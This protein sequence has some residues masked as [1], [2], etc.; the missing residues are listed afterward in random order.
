MAY[1][2]SQIAKRRTEAS[3]PSQTASST[4]KLGSMSSL[5]G[6][7]VTAQDTSNTATQTSALQRQPAALGKLHE[8]DLGAEARALNEERTRRRI[9]GERSLEEE[10]AEALAAK[11]P[12][13]VR[14]GP[15]GKPWRGR[16]KRRG[17]ED[18]KRDMLVEE[19]LRENRRAFPALFRSV[20]RVRMSVLT[21]LQWNY[22]RSQCRQWLPL[23]ATGMMTGQQTIG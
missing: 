7:P 10:E 15:D 20:F 17:S 5:T 4:Q 12:K 2:D 8:V 1:V 21:R 14:L 22:M 6:T 16:K 18:V 13:K 19:L 23:Q 11:N 3:A 9:A